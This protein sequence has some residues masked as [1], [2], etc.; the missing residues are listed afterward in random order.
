MSILPHMLS[1]EPLN[2][3]NVSPS[4]KMIAA[5]I[6]IVPG[7]IVLSLSTYTESIWWYFPETSYRPHCRANNNDT[8]T[9]SVG[10]KVH[11]TVLC[12]TEFIVI[13]RSDNR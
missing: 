2:A 3:P 6:A 9:A 12:Q 11:L 10:G 1:D 13:R 7:G 4:H 8:R 5:F